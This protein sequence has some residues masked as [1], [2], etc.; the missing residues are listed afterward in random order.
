MNFEQ[1]LIENDQR[2]L[3]PISKRNLKVYW[4]NIYFH[5]TGAVSTDPFDELS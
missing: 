5:V 4:L 3:Q 2:E 1:G